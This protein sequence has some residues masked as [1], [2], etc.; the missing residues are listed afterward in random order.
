MDKNGE[1]CNC[2]VPQ[3]I[4]QEYIWDASLRRPDD[5]EY[6]PST[7][8][9]PDSEWEKLTPTFQQYWLI[10]KDHFDWIVIWRRGDWYVT[11]FRDAVKLNSITEEVVRTRN[12]DIGFHKN[13]L[14]HYVNYMVERGLKVLRCEQ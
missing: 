3:F 2:K 12:S 8:H 10:K 9:I 4:R 7:I 5:P 6:D 11:F 13:K 1:I 14:D